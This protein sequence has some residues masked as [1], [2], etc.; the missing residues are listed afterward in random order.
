MVMMIGLSAMS[1][2]VWILASSMARESDAEKRRMS[3]LPGPRFPSTITRDAQAA[4]RAA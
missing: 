1:A 3:E 4:K 2:L